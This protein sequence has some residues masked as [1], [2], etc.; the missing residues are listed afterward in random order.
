MINPRVLVFA[1]H[2]VGYE[3]LRLL[4]ERGVRIVGV[5]THADDPEENIWFRSV[6]SLARDH[7]VPV[8]AP[9]S[10]NSHE[11]IA[12]IRELAPDLIFSFYYRHLIAPE[13]LQ[14]AALG[15]YNMHGSLLPKYRGRAPIN[16]A[17]LHGEP[18]TGATLHVMERRP[19]TGAIIDQE[20]VPIA[21]EATAREVYARVT[22]AARTIL[23]RQLKDLLVGRAPR[24]E[25]D[26]ARA[27][28][29]SGRRPEDG[30]IDW[31]Q[32][33][34]SIFNLV[35]AVTHPYHGAFT[36]IDHKRL[37]IWWAR[38]IACE[39]SRPGEVL[40]SVPL[41]VATGKDCL[42]VGEW[43]WQGDPH[44]SRG[45]SHG[46]RVGLLFGAAS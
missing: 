41:R 22:A 34:R 35:R 9:E 2:D 19:D 40:S 28:Y 36:D 11:W 31:K 43:Q 16:W 13:I 25:Q 12:R 46:L 37:Y 32:D 5:F 42:E 44:P 4:F 45:D 1:Y 17:V 8:F 3:C 20:V 27:T 24:R 26:E 30:R 33:A 39:P 15:A 7:G 38:P 21:P 6:A 29:F 10:I 14:L 18:E 23:E